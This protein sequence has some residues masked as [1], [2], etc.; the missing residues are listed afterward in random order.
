MQNLEVIPKSPTVA[1]ALAVRGGL[2]AGQTGVVLARAGTGKSPFLVQLALD[3]MLRGTDVLHV[4]LDHAQAHVRT[5]YDEIFSELTASNRSGSRTEEALAIERHRVIHSCLGRP[6]LASDLDN[7]MSTLSSVMD[8]SPSLV[9]VDGLEA[10]GIDCAS[11]SAVA[12]RS[13]VRLW[14]GV[15]THRDQ[16][17]SAESLA[18]NFPTAVALEPEGERIS[19][20]IPV[21]YTHLTLPTSDLV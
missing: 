14:L 11:W 13:S 17:P 7:L 3:A 15:R 20:R 4:S 19:I 1:L 21:S 16:G 9:I 2:A 8:F 5:Y 12:R 6:F 10:T 18:A